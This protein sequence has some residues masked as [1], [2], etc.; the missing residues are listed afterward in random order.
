MSKSIQNVAVIGAGITGIT[1]AYALLDRGFNVTIFDK[2]RYAAMETSF[3]NGGQL[4]ASNAEVWTHWGTIFKGIKW[5]FEPGAPLLMNP[6]PSWHKYSWMAEFMGNIPNYRTNTVQT[7]K[8]A[9]EARKHLRSYA[10][11]EGFDFD[12]EDRGI[13]HIYNDP[14]ELAHAR[15]V[16]Q[17]L[18]DGGLERDELSADEVRA[19]EPAIKSDLIGGF[20][21][22]SDFTG[23]IHLYTR[24]L[25]EACARRGAVF[26]H[27]S[28]VTHMTKSHDG[29]DDDWIEYDSAQ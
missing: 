22:K 21:T 24:R 9:I 25:S 26:H 2:N 5:M 7:V 4:S 28:K 6:K 23:D 12:C 14:K 18:K 13:L 29:V 1:T 15:K 11:R 17:L 27:Q 8:M 16:N 10:Q 3:A 20:Y 19:L